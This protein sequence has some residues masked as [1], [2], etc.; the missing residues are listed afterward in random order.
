MILSKEDHA[1]YFMALIDAKRDMLG[2]VNNELN[3]HDKLH[4]VAVVLFFIY[5]AR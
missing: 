3:K 1:A 5:Q 4:Y 2:N